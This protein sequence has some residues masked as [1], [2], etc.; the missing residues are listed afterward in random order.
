[1]AQHA[2]PATSTPTLPSDTPILSDTPTHAELDAV[3]QQAPDLTSRERRELRKLARRQR[4][5]ETWEA[6]RAGPQPRRP[7]RAI[8]SLLLMGATLWVFWLLIGSP[9][10]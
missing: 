2:P 7:H 8:I 6:R 5:I 9:G 10:A 1:M 4:R 3:L